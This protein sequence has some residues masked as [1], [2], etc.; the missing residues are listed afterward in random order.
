M[1]FLYQI[2]GFVLVIVILLLAVLFYLDSKN[3]LAGDLGVLVR[4]LRVLG[5]EAWDAIFNFSKKAGLAED[6]AA[7]LESGADKLRGAAAPDE[8]NGPGDPSAPAPTASPS[9]SPAPFVI[10][11]GLP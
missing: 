10:S 2:I 9:A 3:L 7:I 4:Q 8:T 1:K 5:K 11:F 6:A